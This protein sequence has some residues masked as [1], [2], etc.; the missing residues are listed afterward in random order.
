MA[1]LYVVATPIGNLNDVSARVKN[2]LSSVKLIASEDTRQTLKL[3]NK[4]NISA[5][6]ISYHKF[7]ESQRAEE[8]INKMLTENVDIAIVS[9]AGTPAISDP[10]AILVKLAHEHGIEVI[11]ISGPC[12]LVS[13]LS[14]SGLD[15]TEFAFFGF[16]PRGKNEIEKIFNKIN[17]MQIKTFVLYESPLRILNTLKFI[18]THFYGCKVS[19]SNDLSKLH[20]RTLCGK[21]EDIFNIL[22]NDE[23]A[24]KGEYVIVVQK[25][26]NIK[27]EKLVVEDYTIEA[28]LT[29]IM[30]KQKCTLKDAQ[31]VLHTMCPN[32]SKKDIY[33]AS[34]NL[35]KIFRPL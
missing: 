13:A 16:L 1:K 26:E 5:P 24:K 31:A 17:L 6:L 4:F 22:S 3:L 29:D 15:I 30:L 18:K 28:K 27:Q 35:K 8:I 33:T 2:I 12:A 11:A 23:N 32:Y 25:N 14:V 7:N 20:E 10:G 19:I 9:D 34:L 21:I